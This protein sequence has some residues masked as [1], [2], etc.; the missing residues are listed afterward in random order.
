M[1]WSDRGQDNLTQA[2]RLHTAA[3]DFY[4]RQ[5]ILKATQNIT[6]AL[7]LRR[8]VLPESHPQIVATEEF[9]INLFHQQGLFDQELAHLRR[10]YHLKKLRFGRLHVETEQTML[11]L[12]DLLA[13]LGD[14]AES[15]DLFSEVWRMRAMPS[16]QRQSRDFDDVLNNL[17]STNVRRVDHKKLVDHYFGAGAEPKFRQSP[18][19]DDENWLKHLTERLT[20]QKQTEAMFLAKQ[21]DEEDMKKMKNE[22][23]ALDQPDQQGPQELTTG[24]P[25]ANAGSSDASEAHA[26]DSHTPASSPAEEQQQRI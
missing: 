8:A 26:A 7:R 17:S 9:L 19:A 11:Q 3:I 20:V 4:R 10:L 22:S 15:D 24:G 23:A 12:A 6:E 21:R 18:F 16:T 1:E 25:T 13:Q 5:D 14:K 2:K